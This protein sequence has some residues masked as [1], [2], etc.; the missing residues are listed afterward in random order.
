MVTYS[1]CARVTSDRF[2]LLT[3]GFDHWR[4]CVGKWAISR[5]YAD[6]DQVVAQCGARWAHAYR[7]EIIRIGRWDW[8]MV[9]TRAGER[10]KSWY[11]RLKHAGRLSWN[12]VFQWSNM[13]GSGW[14]PSERV[15]SA[16]VYP[17]TFRL[18]L[19]E[20]DTHPN[21]KDSCCHTRTDPNRTELIEP[22]R[23]ELTRT[24]LTR[25]ETR[26]REFRA[27]CFRRWR[28]RT[29]IRWSIEQRVASTP[30]ALLGDIS[31]ASYTDGRR[32][33]GRAYD[34]GTLREHS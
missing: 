22:I 7:E 30:A 19:S 2:T 10:R 18:Q 5:G 24:E 25:T 3:P 21:A 32:E 27:A 9:L 31:S 8:G 20:L 33:S 6:L 29:S 28:D 26:V 1:G 16:V 11:L 15:A 23:T 17:T 4:R 13:G 34:H 14:A 12:G